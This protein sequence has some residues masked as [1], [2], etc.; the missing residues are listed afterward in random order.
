MDIA[1]LVL[2]WFVMLFTASS[3]VMVVAARRILHAAFSL[4]LC[5]LGVGGIY[6]FLQADFVAAVQLIVYVGG[7]LVL[8]LFA[9]MFSSHTQ[10]ESGE[11][12]RGLVGLLAGALAA[13]GVYY[14]IVLLI[15]RLSPRFDE[16]VGSGGVPYQHTI[17]VSGVQEGLGHLLMGEYLLPFEVVSVLIL[18][19]LIGAVAIVRKE[20]KE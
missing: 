4:C 7:I 20:A 2:F 19:A 11:S 12:P 10:E 14:A 5:F 13:G 8:I 18:A 1:A 15:S 9:V 17:G 6:L 16:L 3:A